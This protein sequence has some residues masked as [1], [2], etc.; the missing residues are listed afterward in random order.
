[1]SRKKKEDS[2]KIIRHMCHN[3]RSSQGRRIEFGCPGEKKVSTE[4][5]TRSKPSLNKGRGYGFLID[6][7]QKDPEKTP[8][9]GG[10]REEGKTKKWHFV[11]TKWGFVS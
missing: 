1:M 7:Y 5:T 9:S 10:G 3:S 11:T 2:K 4:R 6:F 8:C